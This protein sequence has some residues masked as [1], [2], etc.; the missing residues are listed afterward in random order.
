MEYLFLLGACVCFSVQSIFS[1][2]YQ[3]KSGG[4]IKACLVNSIATSFLGALYCIVYALVTNSAI[5]FTM[6]RPALVYSLIY[7]VAGVVATVVFLFGLNF[8]NLSILTTY[9]LLGGMVLPFVYGIFFCNED[10]TLFKCLGTLL[11]LVSLMPTAYDSYKNNNL[12]TEKLHKK[13]HIIFPI[14][15]FLVFFGNGMTG[16]VAKAHQMSENAITSDQFVMLGSLEK[17]LLSLIVFAIYFFSA[18]KQK[19]VGD[20]TS[21]KLS[22]SHI[23]LLGS[24]LLG[25]AVIHSMGDIFSLLCASDMDSS[26]QFSII[27]AFCIFFTAIIGRVLFREKISKP[28]KISFVFIVSGIVFVMLSS[29]YGI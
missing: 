24:F 29:L 4:G 14:L 20:G 19:S 10:F 6:T 23:L 17:A 8:G 12:A 9:S 1:K 21:V 26:I 2:L 16:V 27:S 3:T 22:A 13:S 15:C 7:A 11:L 5:F 25:Y 18:T 28:Q